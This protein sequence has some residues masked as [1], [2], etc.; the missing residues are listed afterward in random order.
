MKINWGAS[1]AIV[2]LLF[3]LSMIL[4]VIKASRQTNDL[5]TENYYDDAVH[6]QDKIDA[7]N[8]SER[9]NSDF[10]ASYSKVENR[11]LI[12][13]SN[14]TGSLSGKLNFYKPDDAQ[15][16]FEVDL[17]TDTAGRQQVAA[18]KMSKGLWHVKA[19]W[20]ING[21][22]YYSESNLFIQ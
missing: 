20:Q 6:Y 11:V 18:N 1:I 21:T 8:N 2:Y 14:S 19:A 22:K 4:F 15:K 13:V 7:K 5:V 16:D 9:F 10:K 17:K 3:V 12:S